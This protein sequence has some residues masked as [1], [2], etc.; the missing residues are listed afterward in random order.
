[1]IEIST[2]KAIHIIF[3]KN[4]FLRLFFIRF[5]KTFITKNKTK[6]SVPLLLQEEHLSYSILRGD[7][8]G[9]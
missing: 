5:F 2:I 4:K 3:N 9:G 6:N 1:M 7:F 8:V